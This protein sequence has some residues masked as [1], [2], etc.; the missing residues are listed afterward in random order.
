MPSQALPFTVAQAVM[1]ALAGVLLALGAL[2]GYRAWK[3]RR[4][5]PEERERRRRAQIAA[6]GKITDAMLVEI[7]DD[8][9]FYSYLVRGVEYVASQDITL[10]KPQMPSELGL[11]AGSVSVKFDPKN[12]AN[13]IVLAE[14]WSGLHSGRTA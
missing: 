10:L 9:L 13:S 8:V 14:D 6:I 7:R 4:I 5:A 12:P 2:W 11:G 3:R 1:L